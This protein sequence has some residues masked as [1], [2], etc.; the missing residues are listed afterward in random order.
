MNRKQIKNWLS[1]KLNFPE[2]AIL[3][4]ETNTYNDLEE[5]FC[6]SRN[7]NF[8]FSEWKAPF[9]ES[10][11]MPYKVNAKRLLSWFFLEEFEQVFNVEL[12]IDKA[13][14][15]PEEIANSVY[16]L[17][18]NTLTGTMVFELL[19]EEKFIWSVSLSLF[20]RVPL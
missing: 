9:L 10:D 7:M 13:N 6:A 11:K 1:K 4:A 17:F 20:V 5:V 18:S 16:L 15:E 3:K 8:D 14:G 2:G 12:A 19:D